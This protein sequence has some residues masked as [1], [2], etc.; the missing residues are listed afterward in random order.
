MIAIIG[1]LSAL[2][3]L[4]LDPA[5]LL[6]Q[7]RDSSRV[8][9]MSMIKNAISIYFSTASQISMGD[10]GKCYVSSAETTERCGGLFSGAYTETNATISE[11]ID[12]TGWLPIDL[13]LV[14]SG[15]P[16]GA[17]PVDPINDSTHYYAFAASSTRSTYELNANMESKKYS[18]NGSKDVEST[19]GGNMDDWYEVGTA[20]G[21]AL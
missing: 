20:Q 7:A 1:M 13:T 6:R 4:V 2:V 21:L 3:V 11:N 12:G 19:D 14:P 5:E 17:F 18:Q 15:A 10:S 8:S 16:I 9:D